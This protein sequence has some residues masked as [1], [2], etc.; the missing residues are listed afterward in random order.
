MSEAQESRRELQSDNHRLQADLD[1]AT[2]GKAK[3]E[4]RSNALT[5]EL[6]ALENDLKAKQADFEQE[7]VEARAAQQAVELQLKETQE[8]Q[9]LDHDSNKRL[10]AQT[11]VC[12]QERL[13]GIGGFDRIVA[14]P[15]R[16]S[17]MSARAV[18]AD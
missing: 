16:P 11:Q 14:A 8:K 4:A 6:D 18:P 2:R 5:A 13:G 1:Q 3:L 7:L 15:A 10:D 17:S 12:E 9:A